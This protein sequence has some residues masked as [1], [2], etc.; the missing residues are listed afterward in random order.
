MSFAPDDLAGARFADVLVVAG[1]GL[2]RRREDRLRQPVRLAQ[3]SRQRNAANCAGFA[4]ILPARAG[5]ISARDAFD[6]Q[7]LGLPHEHRAAVEH[8]AVRR[9]AAGNVS[10]STD[11]Q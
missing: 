7:R 1:L 6:R 2:G 8:V 10:T 9:A 4:V 3:A 11:R 5:E